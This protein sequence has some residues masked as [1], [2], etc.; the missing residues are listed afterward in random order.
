M[1]TNKTGVFSLIS[2]EIEFDDTQLEEVSAK[3]KLLKSHRD[4]LNHWRVFDSIC[5]FFSVYLKC[6]S[7]CLINS[8]DTHTSKT[9]ISKK[10][11]LL[12]KIS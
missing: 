6:R 8:I 2:M 10:E 5:F 3:L 9:P 1:H 12:C 4:V 7:V 11:E